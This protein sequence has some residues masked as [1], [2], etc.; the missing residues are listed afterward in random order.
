MKRFLVSI[1]ILFSL[2]I[3][4]DDVKTYKQILDENEKLA[5][6]FS[7]ENLRLIDI[8]YKLGIKSSKQIEDESIKRT[9]SYNEMRTVKDFSDIS[10]I[11]N[12]FSNDKLKTIVS[13][14]KPYHKSYKRASS[15]KI[16]IACAAYEL[17]RQAKLD[18]DYNLSRFNI[19][20]ELGDKF[21]EPR[22]E[23]MLFTDAMDAL[24]TA[25]GITYELTLMEYNP[26]TKECKAG[27]TIILK[28]RDK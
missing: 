23:K 17:C 15:S 16:T 18:F 1:V 13:L 10:A 6:D 9:N 12:K 14:H 26:D 3:Y 22:I 5:K 7:E 8:D 27:G 4:G 21:I 2:S 25:E 28:L 11:A 19:T 24:L 20:K